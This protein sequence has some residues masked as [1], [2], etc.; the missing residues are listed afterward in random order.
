[1]KKIHKINTYLLE[2]YPLIWNTRLLWMILINFLS[3]LLFFGMGFFAISDMSDLKLRYSLSDYYSDTSIIY[4]N[5]LISILTLLIWLVFYLRNNAFKNFY[6][7]SRIALF[8][9]FCILILVLF[10]SVTQ[11]LSFSQGI[12]LKVR[13]TFDWQEVDRDIKSFNRTSIFLAQSDLDYEIDKKRYPKPFPL[14]VAHENI[15]DPVVKIDTTRAFFT[16]NGF[17]YQFYKVDH[18]FLKKFREEHLYGYSGGFRDRIVKDVSAFKE[19]ITPTLLNYSKELFGNGQDSLDYSRQL[20]SH[21]TVLSESDPYKIE[22]ELK[23]MIHLLDKYQVDHNVTVQKWLPLVNNPPLYRLKTLI[24]TTNPEKKPIYN[25]RYSSVLDIKEQYDTFGTS[26]PYSKDLYCDFGRL[27]HF[28]GNVY[29][30]YHPRS[31]LEF[32]SFVLG[33]VFFFGLLL[34]VFKTTSLKSLLLSIVS[35]I[36]LIVIVVMLMN[37]INHAIDYASNI[38]SNME[39]NTIIV[40]SLLV[41]LASYGSFVF[42]W[43]K[44]IATILSSLALYAA[45]LFM[46]FA[47]LRYSNMLKDIHGDEY[48][49]GFVGWFQ[50]NGFWLVMSFWILAI[51]F[52]CILIKELKARPED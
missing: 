3:H 18:E 8:K 33:F 29:Y 28:F 52:Y 13:N 9:Q 14:K 45:P 36:V 41:M 6:T 27:D 34:F 21:Q 19:H 48:R 24:H 47:S 25:N 26:I 40:I 17:R 12:A 15:N 16:Y 20:E 11:Y 7:L 22:E 10:I 35:T 32:V 39:Y 44:I 42:K 46:L 51:F 50:E 2:H 37:Y 49:E 23:E 5:Y 31:I 30:A 4:Y 43:K 1:M 38:N